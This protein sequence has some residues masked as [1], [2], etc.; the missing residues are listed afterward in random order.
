[1]NRSGSLSRQRRIVSDSDNESY[2]RGGVDSESEGSFVS[3][4]VRREDGGDESD[5]ETRLD[6]LSRYLQEKV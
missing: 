5:F 4:P 2:T 6:M 1:M 3:A